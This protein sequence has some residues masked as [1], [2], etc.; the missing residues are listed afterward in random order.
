MRCRPVLIA[1]TLLP[2]ASTAQ[3]DE[4]GSFS[5]N[6]TG[7]EIVAEAIAD[8]EIEGVTCHTAHF[9]RGLL[10]RLS[11]GNWL[12]DPSNASID[13]WQTGPLVTGDISLDEE[14]EEVFSTSRP[15]PMLILK[16]SRTDQDH[17][18]P[19]HEQERQMVLAG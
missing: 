18:C 9:E 17:S 10:D 1:L 14:G 6:W 7:N 19:N 2:A 12:E 16:V 3:A 15:R 8:P 11:K 4:V 13:C 5:N